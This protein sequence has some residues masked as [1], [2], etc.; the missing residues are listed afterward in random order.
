[1]GI[2]KLLHAT[3]CEQGQGHTMEVTL[4]VIRGSLKGHQGRPEEAVAS[5]R[6]ASSGKTQVSK[7]G[8]SKVELDPAAWVRL[9]IGAQLSFLTLLCIQAVWPMIPQTGLDRTD[10]PLSR[11]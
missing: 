6:S 11:H 2:T 5:F 3:V 4:E 7:A 8:M 10:V 9:P 1:M